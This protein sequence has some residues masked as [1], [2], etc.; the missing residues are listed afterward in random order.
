VLTSTSVSIYVDG[1][2]RN[3][4]NGSP[5]TIDNTFPMTVGGKLDC[6]QIDITC[7]YYSGQID[8]VKITKS[9]PVNQPP[10]ANFAPSCAALLCSFDSSSSSD[11]DGTIA[12]YAWD[13][14]DGSASTVASPH[15][16]YDAAGSYTVSLTVKDN[17]NATASVTKSVNVSDQTSGSS[18][19]FV[20]SAVSAANSKT[21]TVT[22]PAAAAAGQRL[23]LVLSDNDP[24]QTVSDPTGVTGWTRLGSVAAKT[25][26]TTV[27]TKVAGPADPGAVLK[28]AVSA[29]V[30]HTITVAAYDGV[31]NS[32]PGLPFASATDVINGHTARATPT[33]TAPD[34]AW[35]ASYWADK[36][37]NTTAWTPESSVVTRRA[38]CAADAGHICS[39]YADSGQPV[40]AGT[41]GAITASTNA[42]SDQ[43]TMWSIVLPSAT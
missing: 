2:F 17:S 5:G 43:A 35:V 8:Y 34:G 15:H 36:S 16:L 37:A 41:Y 26:G 1:V 10:V 23:V 29:A 27:W 33:V 32:L 3:K 19:A 22:V 28:V 39:A 38:A 14:G 7:D 30:K 24:T 21:P 13:F 20:G 12:S 11:P 40:P 42:P 31:D 4:K 25:M 9:L 6:D 18:V